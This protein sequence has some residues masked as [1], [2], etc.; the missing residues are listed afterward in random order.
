MNDINSVAHV[1][2]TNRAHGIIRFNGINHANC[3]I[4]ANGANSGQGQASQNAYAN[5]AS[6]ILLARCSQ[7]S[8]FSARLA[9]G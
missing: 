5:T 9:W 3:M 4:N 1:Q 8:V 7:E 6:R 2:C